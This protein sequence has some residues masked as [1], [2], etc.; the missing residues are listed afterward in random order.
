MC[1]VQPY[2]PQAL[3]GAKT[4][5]DV[6]V[7]Q[8]CVV[9]GYEEKDGVRACARPI[10]EDSQGSTE[11]GTGLFNMRCASLFIPT[12]PKSVV[13]F[14]HQYCQVTY[15]ELQAH[16]KRIEMAP[17]PCAG[18]WTNERSSSRLSS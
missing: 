17:H 14:R 2:T 12:D 13:Q 4:Y 11:D 5:L 10:A 9:Y 18:V 3:S 1:Q 15:A 7:I 8:R 6:E 16:P